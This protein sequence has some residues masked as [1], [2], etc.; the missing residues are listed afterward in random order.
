MIPSII[1]VSKSGK[2]GIDLLSYDFTKNRKIYLFS[3]IN[4]NV[5]METIAQLEYLDSNG[6]EDIKIYINS[7]GGSV[8]AGFAI[9]DAINRCRCDVSTICIGMAASMGAFILSCG[10]KGKR[11]GSPLSEIMIHQP[12]GGAQGQASDIQLAAEHITKVKNKL[13]RVLSD[14]TGQS[15]Q[16]ISHDCDRDFWMDTD[17]ALKYGIID[18][19][20]NIQS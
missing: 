3:E 1:S 8:S 19:I 9:V 10:T 17:E 14:N 16:T 18:G 2:E 11:Y 6:A 4:D 12:L 7:P 5:A 13:H 15:I 20:F